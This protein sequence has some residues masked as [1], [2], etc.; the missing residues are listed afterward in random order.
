MQHSA[1]SQGNGKTEAFG[2]NPLSPLDLGMTGGRHTH[3][4]GARRRGDA[5]KVKGLPLMTLIG[6]SSMQQSA[7]SKSNGKTGAFGMNPLSPLDLGMT[8][9]GVTQLVIE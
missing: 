5:E 6:R 2:M 8:G 1:I 7:I 9:G 3:H 4:E